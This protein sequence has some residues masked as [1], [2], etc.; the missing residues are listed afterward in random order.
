MSVFS[1]KTEEECTQEFQQTEGMQSEEPPRLT[2][3][4]EIEAIEVPTTEYK[5]LCTLNSLMPTITSL[6]WVSTEGEEDSEEHRL[7]Q[8]SYAAYYKFVTLKR[9]LK[10]VNPK[11]ETMEMLGE[12]EKMILRRIAQDS[13]MKDFVFSSHERDLY[14]QIQFLYEILQKRGWKFGYSDKYNGKTLQLLSK[15]KEG[16]QAYNMKFG[17]APLIREYRSFST[18]F[19][20]IGVFKRQFGR[21]LML[22]GIFGYLAYTKF[23]ALS[24]MEQLLTT[25]I[26][27]MALFAYITWRRKRK[28]RVMLEIAAFEAQKEREAY[29][30]SADASVESP[31]ESFSQPITEEPA[32]SSVEEAIEDT[33]TNVEY[34]KED[35]SPASLNQEN[36]IDN[37]L[38]EIWNRYIGV[39]TE[40]FMFRKPVYNEHGD[41]NMVLFV[42]LNPTDE[43]LSGVELLRSPSGKNLYYPSYDQPSPINEF[44][45]RQRQFAL[46]LGLNHGHLNLLYAH[47]NDRNKLVHANPDFIR[48]QLEVTY[49]SIRMMEPKVIVFLSDYCHNLVYG[50][51]RWTRPSTKGNYDVLNGTEIPVLF[52]DDLT[53]ISPDELERIQQEV[54]RLLGK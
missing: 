53:K 40:D 29:E 28:Q 36:R 13:D 2:T 26:A 20:F 8:F 24:P 21:F 22:I 48:E 4:E 32:E 49:E 9:A 30:T 34:N 17:S 5:I 37:R 3:I 15:L 39:V 6:Q 16:I 42:S 50:T 10:R 19:Y 41:Q 54:E 23:T 52:I 43:E 1:D 7:N 35:E 12:V 25:V 31:T 27:V 33:A 51:D 18:R 44:V 45:E 14:H 47:E 11:H 38:S 46:N